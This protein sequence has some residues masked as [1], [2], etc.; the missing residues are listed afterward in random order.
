MVTLNDVILSDEVLT[1]TI[2]VVDDSEQNREALIDIL[3]M[4]GFQTMGAGDGQSAL[5]IIRAQAP[6]L[7]LL[8]VMLP[9][10][11]G[12]KVLQALRADPATRELPVILA[13][14]LDQPHDMVY[15]LELGANDY[16]VKPVHPEILIARVRTQLKLRRLQEQRLAD[17]TRMQDQDAIKDKFLQIA[18]HD[19][20]NPISNILAAA[21]LL[22]QVDPAL[23]A[24]IDGYDRILGVIRN[25]GLLMQSIVRDFLDHDALR[26][27]RLTLDLRPVA[28]N[29]LVESVIAQFQSTADKKQIALH[30]DLDPAVGEVTADPARLMQI[31]SNLIGNALKFSLPGGM[32]RMRTLEAGECLRVEVEDHGP[33]IAAEEMPLL[34][35]EFA[36]LRNKPT[37][38]ERS[39]GLGLAIA[40]QL[41]ELH[42]GLIGAKS[43]VGHGSTFWFEIPR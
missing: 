16:L 21:D 40:R 9:E 13:T 5:D 4:E 1:G 14:V 25:S 26:S 41:V 35:Q 36:R 22:T 29:P 27:G 3:T 7:V 34:F 17:L 6:D 11:N 23:M 31:A 10:I 24:Q 15:G 18:A 37:G 32:V 12:M 2:L 8:D 43:E 28:L 33:G 39:S 38:G 30:A 20:K 19:L 42:G